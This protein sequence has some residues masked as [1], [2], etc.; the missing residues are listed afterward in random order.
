MDNFSWGNTRVVLGESGKKIYVEDVDEYDTS[1]VIPEM[2]WSE[3]EQELLKKYH[4]EKETVF[5]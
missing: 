5:Q 2:R 1:F 4:Q 3:H